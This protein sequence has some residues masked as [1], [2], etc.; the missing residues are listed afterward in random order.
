MNKRTRIELAEHLMATREQ[1]ARLEEA[2]FSGGLTTRRCAE[3]VE[4][5]IDIRDRCQQA[6]E[7]LEKP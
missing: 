6:I 2:S 5:L 4:H 1:L 3:M 7:M